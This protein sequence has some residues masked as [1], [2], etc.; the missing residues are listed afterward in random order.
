MTSPRE[1]ASVPTR[2]WKFPLPMPDERGRVFIDMPAVVE[3]L[4]VGLQ[5]DEMFVW[6]LVCPDAVPEP[7]EENHGPRRFIVANTGSEIADFPEGASFLGTV[8][9]SNRMVWHV[10]DGDAETTA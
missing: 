1:Q 3:P 2:V 8:T 5:D 6:A 10:W 4:S 9:T 7:Y